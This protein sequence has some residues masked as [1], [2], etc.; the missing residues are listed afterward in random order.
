MQKYAGSCPGPKRYLDV[1]YIQAVVSKVKGGS[2]LYYMTLLARATVFNRRSMAEMLIKNGAGKH[3]T[4][5]VY[6]SQIMII[7][8]HRCLSVYW[9]LVQLKHVTSEIL[10]DFRFCVWT[11]SRRPIEHAC[12]ALN[13]VNSN[14]ITMMV[15]LT[16]SVYNQSGSFYEHTLLMVPGWKTS[17]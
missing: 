6:I 1:C 16:L 15:E 17:D 7:R 12:I 10:P 4:Q 14:T 9:S 5:H 13:L 3:C 2:T 11:Y 8:H